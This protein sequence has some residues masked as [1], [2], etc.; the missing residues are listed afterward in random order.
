MAHSL[1]LQASEC[2]GLFGGTFLHEGVA[3]AVGAALIVNGHLSATLVGLMLFAGIVSGD[4][5][6]YGLGAMARRS[7][8]AQRRIAH[9]R[10]NDRQL[11][12][13]KSALLAVPVCHL[14]PWLLFPTFVAF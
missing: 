14:V 11:W 2:L 6:I 1:V 9:P 8:W 5:A 4:C 7:A 3:L 13:S 12:Q 10:L